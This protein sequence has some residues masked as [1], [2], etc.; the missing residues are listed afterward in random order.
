MRE[1]IQLSET[2]T[3]M[4]GGGQVVGPIVVQNNVS[5]GAQVAVAV[6]ALSPNAAV[7]ANT[8]LYSVQLNVAAV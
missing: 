2:E 7:G 5:A 4:V 6:A 1:L 3:E 8:S